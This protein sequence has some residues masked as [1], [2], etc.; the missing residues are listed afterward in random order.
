[1]IWKTWFTEMN[2]LN[3]IH[4]YI[5]ITIFPTCPFE[6]LIS[7]GVYIFYSQN[8]NTHRPIRLSDGRTYHN[9]IVWHLSQVGKSHYFNSIMYYHLKPLVVPYIYIYIYSIYL[10]VADSSWSHTQT[11]MLTEPGM[12]IQTLSSGRGNIQETQ[13]NIYQNLLVAMRKLWCGIT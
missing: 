13:M 11:T 2:S 9:W 12:V 4:T 1:M 5:F 6:F 8:A 10:W 7:L 3:H